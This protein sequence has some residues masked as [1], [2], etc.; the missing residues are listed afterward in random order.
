[1]PVEEV[2][3]DLAQPQA[4]QVAQEEVVQAAQLVAATA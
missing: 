1:M 3:V 2:V 4:V